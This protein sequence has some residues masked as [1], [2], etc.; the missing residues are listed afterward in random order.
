MATD[1]G[2]VPVCVNA[3]TVGHYHRFGARKPGPLGLGGMACL[4]LSAG[5]L[6]SMDVLL[7]DLQG[8]PAAGC[9]EV[10]R[11]PEVSGG[12]GAVDP[13]DVVLAHSARVDALE[14]VDQ[15]GEGE[16]RGVVEERVGVVGFV[17]DLARFGAEVLADLP[18]DLLAVGEHLVV[19]HATPVLGDEYQVDVQ[20]PDDAP[21]TS[22]VGIGW[23]VR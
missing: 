15:P 22:D 2:V 7:D 11:R 20:V 17:V 13:A 21:A 4:E 9:G 19:E 8:C 12:A 1:V 18:H 5:P 6:L 14:A 10:G 23:P 16:R 3:V